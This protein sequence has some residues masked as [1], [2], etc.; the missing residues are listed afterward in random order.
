MRGRLS[1]KLIRD[2]LDVSLSTDE[3]DNFL[4]WCSIVQCA[5]MKHY[6]LLHCRSNLHIIF[7]NYHDINLQENGHSLFE[8][9]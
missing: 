7:H 3:I 1:S 4:H 9:G 8:V 2:V 5:K 6:Y